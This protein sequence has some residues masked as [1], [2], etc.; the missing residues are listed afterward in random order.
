M[1]HRLRHFGE[2]R[3][4]A[5]G[6]ELL[7]D[8]PSIVRR[9]RFERKRDV[10]RVHRLK[11]SLQLDQVLPMLKAFQQVALGSLLTLGKVIEDPVFVEQTS[12]L[13]EALLQPRVGAEACHGGPSFAF[14]IAR[15]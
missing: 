4:S 7:P 8:R 10:R 2:H 11:A 5:L 15:G 9:Q 12:D 14:T 3:A 1:K 13:V 6:I